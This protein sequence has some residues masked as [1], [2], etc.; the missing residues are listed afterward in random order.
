MKVI[1][2]TGV[3]HYPR[4]G[5]RPEEQGL[6]R[7]LARRDRGGITDDELRRV[8]DEV[9]CE[10]IGEQCRSGID[11]V[12]DG[13]VRWNDPLTYIAGRLEGIRIAGLTRW[14][15]TNTYFRQ[16]QVE[17]AVRWRRPITVDDYRFA[18]EHSDRPVK[19]V[20]TGPFTLGRLSD[21]RHYRDEDRLVLDYARALADEVAALEAAGADPIQI[22]E[23]AILWSPERFDLLERGIVEV[24]RGRTRAR[25]A[26]YTYFRPAGD[27]I[28][29]LGG[30]PVDILGLDLAE[31]RADVERL[32]SSP[33]PQI[34]AAGI[35]N[36]RNTRMED[37]D[38]AV[39]VARRLYRASRP[40]EMFLN[41]STGLEFLP[42][43]AARRKLAL[44]A[45]IAARANAETE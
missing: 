18:A 21:D 4:I 8:E 13:Q 29:R 17:S 10:V 40:R 26:L 6:R 38:E 37:E 20:L 23:P 2:A 16:P 3:G 28:G 36:G 31:G 30:L 27:L 1:Q 22:D 33:P 41:P 45:R 32:E 24:A 5:D 15:D 7:A 11:L 34:L 35:L 43:E 9:T 44:L 25:L 12:T 19:P 14:F 42:R 39:A